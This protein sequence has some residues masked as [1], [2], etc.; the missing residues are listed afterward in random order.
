MQFYMLSD[1]FA[2]MRLACQ[3]VYWSVRT[4]TARLFRS[5]DKAF[6]SRSQ[7]NSIC[8][9]FN[10]H[11]DLWLVIWK[12]NLF[13]WLAP[14]GYELWPMSIAKIL[15]TIMLEFQS[16]S[17][18][19]LSRFNWPSFSLSPLKQAAQLSWR[20]T[21]EKKQCGMHQ[22]RRALFLTASFVSRQLFVVLISVKYVN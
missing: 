9:L 18:S 5:E 10:Q 14:S 16:S 1:Q 11:I 19:I 6:W 8:Y 4:T 3:T 13:C 2:D 15:F 12:N 20:P 21:L 7:C 22:S 17:G